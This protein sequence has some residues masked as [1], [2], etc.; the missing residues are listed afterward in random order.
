MG[1]ITLSLWAFIARGGVVL[2]FYLIPFLPVLALNVG[3]IL[4]I[5]IEEIN[6]LS[7]HIYLRNISQ[8]KL[9]RYLLQSGI[10]FFCLFSILFSFLPVAKGIGYRSTN[11]GNP[12][13]PLIAWNGVQADAQMESIVWVEQHIPH[14]SRIIIDMF[15]WPDLYAAGYYNAHYYWKFELDPAIRAGVFH[16]NWH[17]VDYLITSPQMLVDM[18]NANFTDIL[19]MIQNSSTIAAFDTGHWRIDIRKIHK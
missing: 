10:A 1:L 11:V 7:L 19:S 5:F 16:D 12:D 6:R 18:S 8:S 4:S 17:N 13:N 15:M 14:N 2:D 9:L 3:L